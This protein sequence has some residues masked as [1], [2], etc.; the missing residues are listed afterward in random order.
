MS[1]EPSSNEHLAQARELVKVRPEQVKQLEGLA[2]VWM[3]Q[4][5]SRPPANEQEREHYRGK[6]QEFRRAI[7][8]QLQQ[9]RAAVLV[10]ADLLT[11]A[12][13]LTSPQQAA[14]LREQIAPVLA[15]EAAT[16]RA[17]ASALEV[18]VLIDELT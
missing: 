17:V 7:D 10:A 13:G 3:K 9:A 6:A 8:G 18:C 15:N 11:N 12:D 5:R 16:A 2:D 14:A 1:D 4:L